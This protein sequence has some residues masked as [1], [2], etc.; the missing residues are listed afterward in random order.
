M[1]MAGVLAASAGY[2]DS[3]I[4]SEL[5]FVV[6]ATAGSEDFN[7][8]ELREMR[9]KLHSPFHLAEFT[10]PHTWPPAALLDQALGWFELQ[11]MRSGLKAR[12]ASLIDALFSEQLQ[13]AATLTPEAGLPALEALRTDFSELH[14]LTAVDNRIAV[15]RGQPAVRAAQNAAAA[16]DRR[17]R[18]TMEEVW[19]LEE[20]LQDATLRRAAYAELRV[21]WQQ[22]V[23]NAALPADGDER[24]LARRLLPNLR[25]SMVSTDAEY[26]SMVETIAPARGRPSP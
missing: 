1:Q 25:S 8:L 4:R 2:P 10:G 13:A 7:R 16:M 23:A 24:R 22:L 14:D 11:A 20:Q 26:R 12:D 3:K 6:F 18:R 5:P 17:E 21:R 15:L 19:A 9:A